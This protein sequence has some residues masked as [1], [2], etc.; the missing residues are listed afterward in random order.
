MAQFSNGSEGQ[1]F[2]NECAN[3]I[4]G[5]LPCPIAWVQAEYNYE[6][7]NNEV[8]SAILDYLVK[9]SGECAMK[10]FMDKHDNEP[11]QHRDML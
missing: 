3:C 11:A 1:A 10:K 7:A 2:E 5:E 8:A 4:Y 9:D 6:A